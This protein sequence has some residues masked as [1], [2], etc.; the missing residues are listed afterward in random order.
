MSVGVIAEGIKDIQRFYEALPDATLEAAVFAINDTVRDTVPEIRREMRKEVSFPSGYLEGGDRLYIKRKANKNTLEAVITGRDRPT[1]LARFAPAGATPENSRGREIMLRVKP[2]A[3]AKTR[4]AWLV[5]LRNGNMGLA[6]RLKPGESLKN[7]SGA[8][9]L[10][11]SSHKRPDAN[12]YLLYGPSVDQ[13]LR[14]VADDLTP[15]ILNKMASNFT[16]QFGRISS[17]A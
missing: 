17:R 6:I 2:G 14:G 9:L 16:R 5:N 11:G 8:V 15:E 4:R 1:S 13:V 10:A 3:V 7:T 12:V